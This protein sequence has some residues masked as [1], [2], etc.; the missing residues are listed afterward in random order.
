MPMVCASKLNSA[1]SPAP[2]ASM[3]TNAPHGTPAPMLSTVATSLRTTTMSRLA[4]SGEE[5][6]EML[7]SEAL[8]R[9]E[10]KACPP[11][12]A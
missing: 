5:K 8:P 11:P 12:I 9:S 10:M 7:A 4:Q 2:M 6:T 1:P 3:G